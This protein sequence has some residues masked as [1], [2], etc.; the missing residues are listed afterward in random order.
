[1]K[2]PSFLE[3]K[4]LVEYLAEQ[5][6]GAQL[7]EVLACEEGLVLTFYRF[8][9]QPKT[10]YLVFDLDKPFPFLGFYSENP[11]R[12]LKKAKP[13]GLFLN[14]HAKNQY[15]NRIELNEKLGRVVNF[16]FSNG[17]QTCDLEF[18]MIPKHTNLIVTS[19]GKSISWY[20][21]AELNEVEF[22]SQ[23][24]NESRSIPFIM[25][26]WLERRGIRGKN[27]TQISQASQ[28]PYEKWK[29]NK[30]KDLQ[31]KKKALDGIQAQIEK[32][33]SEPWLEVGEF[34]KSYSL[35]DLK[36]EWSIYVDFKKT[37]SKN[38]QDCFAKA[39][40]AKTKISGALKRY[41]LIQS[42]IENLSDLSEN[43][44]EN[45][46]RK[47]NKD[48]P[49]PTR[50]IEGRYRKMTSEESA[51]IA[52][53]GKNAKDN[54]D[55]LRKSKAWD[56]WMHLKDYPSAHAI[57][58][59]QKDQSVSDADLVKF[60][61]WL[62]KEGLPEKKFQLGGKFNVVIVECR[63]VRPIKGDKLGRVTYH[64]AREILIAI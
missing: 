39:K 52:Y 55:L 60:S 23:L 43:A 64:H 53:M 32:L 42:E 35:K 2:T 45:G 6:L 17:Q 7:Q 38:M 1:M 18:R 37:T 28:S 46:L 19:G 4:T 8:T 36:P 26:Q 11:W 62:L 9:L 31:K 56:F 48:K 16:H 3:L 41:E 57:I 44:F 30:T 14:A 54:I 34:L 63:H 15:L 61:K 47:K 21:V 29:Q 33:K 24:E 51:L 12:H 59:R 5:L 13:T 20:P 49:V 58:H 22:N 50:T 40:A 27:S 25:N 10:M